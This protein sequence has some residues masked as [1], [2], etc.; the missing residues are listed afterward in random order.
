MAEAAES[1]SNRSAF[2]RWD[3]YYGGA[4]YSPFMFNYW[5][6]PFGFYPW[7]RF[8][9]SSPFM[10]NRW[11][12]PYAS[13]GYPSVTYDANSI[14]LLS[15]DK[16]GNLQSIKT[17][18]KKQ[19]DQNVDQ[20]IGFGTIDNEDGTTFVYHQKQKGMH[21]LVINTLTKNGQLVKGNALVLNEKNYDWMPKMLKQVGNQEAILPYQYKSR[22]GFAKIKFK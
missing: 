16:K 1:Y 11:M 10:Y 15:F 21:Q 9:W 4:F 17:I 8:G 14:A 19:S 22:I 13:F 18:D 2:S 7:A 3:Y 20:F 5:N 6:R 12:N